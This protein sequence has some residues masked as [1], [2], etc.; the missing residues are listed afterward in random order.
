MKNEYVN[1]SERTI[2]WLIFGICATFFLSITSCNMHNKT[3][4]AEIL[5][6]NSTLQ[7]EIHAAEL[8]SEKEKT[9]QAKDVLDSIKELIKI[10]V[11]PIAS[12]CAVI[13]SESNNNCA[14]FITMNT[15]LLKLRESI[16][17]RI[18]NDATNPDGVPLR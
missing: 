3:Y 18:K 1:L 6:I 4:E 15:K 13:G 9:K 12:R 8:L 2:A 10:G 7:K 14:A 16:E 11:N 17:G 5:K